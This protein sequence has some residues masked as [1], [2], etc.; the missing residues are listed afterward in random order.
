[1]ADQQDFNPPSVI[2]GSDA[3][4]KISIPPPPLPSDQN[5]STKPPRTR[6]IADAALLSSSLPSKPSSRPPNSDTSSNITNSTD[7]PSSSTGPSSESST[8][9][10]Q[11]KPDGLKRSDPFQFGTRYLEE[12]DDEFAFNAWDHVEVD[13]DYKAYAEGQY[14]MQRSNPV[15]EFDKNRFNSEPEKWWNNFYKNNRENFFKDRKWLQQEASSSLPPP[16]TPSSN[17]PILTTATAETSPPIRLLEVGC[18]AGNTLFPI[19]SSN[20][21]PNF[22]IHGADF[23]KTSIELIR[24]NELY[25]LHHP[26]HVSASVWDLGNAD[27]VLPEGIEPESLD[28]VILIFVF[29][30]LHPDQWAHAVNNVNKCLKK[31]GKVLF[32]DY[33]RG[34][35][36]QVRFKKGRFLQEN[37][38]IRGDGTRVYFFDRD[39][40][41]R[42]MLVNRARKIKMHR[43]WLQGLFVKGGDEEVEKTL[44]E[45][46]GPE[47]QWMR[48]AHTDVTDQSQEKEVEQ[49]VDTPGLEEQVKNLD[50]GST[51]S[52]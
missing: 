5:P 16:F 9:Q 52:V 1:M 34:D 11:P 18:G 37:F 44:G 19:L 22:H 38:Y 7:T 49:I 2:N 26:K 23:S 13:D 42:R 47:P 17:F 36:A 25:T 4:S 21:N 50:L 51:P 6:Q 48:V 20:K 33:G 3:H 41:D 35:L 43:C 45:Q 15:R 8:T 28:V 39:E 27:G 10:K 46:K 32:R 24:S 31:G 29:S 14:D 40:L 12:G 30:A